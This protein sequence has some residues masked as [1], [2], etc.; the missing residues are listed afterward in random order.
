MFPEGISDG[1]CVQE[2]HASKK[3]C[4]CKGENCNRGDMDATTKTPTTTPPPTNKQ[5]CLRC[6]AG[7][8]CFSDDSKDGESVECQAPTN[9]GCY[10]ALVGKTKL[11]WKLQ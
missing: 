7:E 1:M 8:N 3:T 6:I 4:Y 5:K 2:D 10:K 11:E 9:T